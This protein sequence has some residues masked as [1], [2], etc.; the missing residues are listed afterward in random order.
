M[1]FMFVCILILICGLSLAA[2]VEGFVRMLDSIN[3]RKGE[4]TER[5]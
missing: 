3:N 1:E 2:G 4:F 5:N